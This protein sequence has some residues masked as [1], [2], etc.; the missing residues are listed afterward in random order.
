MNKY[1]TP[2]S[3]GELTPNI[4]EIMGVARPAQQSFDPNPDVT[5]KA[6]ECFNGRKAQKAF[7]YASDAVGDFMFQRHKEFFAPLI[8]A[9]DIQVTGT[10]VMPSITPVCFGTIFSG[11]TPDIHGIHQYEKPVI[12]CET[13][14]D[15]LA[16][17]EKRVAILSDNNCSIDR[18]FRDRPI[19]YYTSSTLDFT[20]RLAK[21][22]LQNYD[23]DVI[24]L[25]DGRYDMYMHASGT[26]SK[27]AIDSLTNGIERYLEIIDI[28]DKV[29][30][31]YD[32]VSVYSPDHGAHDL[33]TGRGTHGDDI[34]DDMLVNHFYRFRAGNNF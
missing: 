27:I 12:K 21:D 19:D 2:H 32:R 14:F 33:D 6:L 24:L 16:K 31:K 15:V 7:F 23:Y 22:V 8:Q 30:G 25:Y 1:N 20:W 5:A 26:E 28:M 13:L 11:V 34:A 9:S 3:T 18:I 10:T 29:W 17:A 4:C